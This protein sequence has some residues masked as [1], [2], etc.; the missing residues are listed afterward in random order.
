MA[1]T[2]AIHA[3]IT[4]L[5]TAQSVTTAITAPTFARALSVTGA[6]AG[7]ALTG[8]VTLTGTDANGEPITETLALDGANT[9]PGRKGFATVT[10]IDVPI[11]ITAAD[12]VSVGVATTLFSVAEARAFDK[13]QLANSVSYSDDAILAAE[14]RIRRYFEHVCGVAFIPTTRTGYH[15][16]S[17]SASLLFNDGRLQAVTSAVVYDS[18]GSVVETF[19]ATDLSDLA[20]YSY[21]KIVRQS[22]GTFPSGHR[23]VKITRV[24]GWTVC[25]D[26]IRRA[27][28]KLAV[29][30]LVPSNISGFSTSVSGGDQTFVL[31]VAGRTN[32]WT[33]DPEIDSI[34]KEY[35]ERLPGVA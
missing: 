27:A 25:P 22:R 9:V 14:R 2:T 32:Q 23:N 18:A 16:G 21:G 17:G 8:N 7:A 29:K 24:H 6:P 31:S 10:A 12:T 5:A 3:A 11:R 33:G 13:G 15:D 30:E 1:N 20:I 19:D 4:L 35:S 26:E 28:L 34:L